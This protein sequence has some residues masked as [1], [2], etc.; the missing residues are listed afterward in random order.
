[1]QSAVIIL[2]AR[3]SVPVSGPSFQKYGC[4]TTCFLLRLNG[5]SVL[6]DA[7]TGLM[8]LP[9]AEL[10]APS[11][12]LLLTHPH[13][14]HLSG[15]PLCPYVMRSGKRLNVY[16]AR[17]GGL[18][19]REQVLRLLSPPLWP[20]T[21]DQLPAEFRF[22]DL[23][24]SLDLYGEHGPERCG[25]QNE[26][27]SSLDLYGEHGAGPDSGT[28]NEPGNDAGIIH[29]ERME[30]IHPGGVS[31][32][33]V[34]GGGKSVVIMTDCTLTKDLCPRAAAFARD[35]ALLLCDGQYSPAEWPRVSGFGHSTWPD[36]AQ[37]GRLC[38][39]RQVR[40]IHHDPRRTDEELDRAAGELREIH[41]RCAFAREGEEIVL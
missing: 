19:G 21:P 3:G 14:D 28:N 35:C 40:V 9:D 24:P 1:M 34:S 38:G 26:A 5:R 11:L 22:H 41:P 4:A 2:G 8:N 36:A 37:F 29:V 27:N 31:L 10:S 16:A 39:A 18:N 25:T 15:L 30:G 20:V 17:H 7:G 23:P 32:L 12:P 6:V 13:A 33:R